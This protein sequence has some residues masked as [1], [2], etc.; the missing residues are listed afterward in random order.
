VPLENRV[1]FLTLQSGQKVEFPFE[2]LIVFATNIRPE[3]LVDEAFLRRIQYKIFAQS[4]TP[5]EFAQIFEN[6]CRKR[7][8]PYDPA[9]VQWLFEHH[10]H[11]RRRPLRAC[12]PRDLISQALSLAEY[13]DEPPVLTRA[14]LDAACETYFVDD[15][16][17]PPVEV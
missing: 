10:Y 8:I 9:L 14:F 6:Y 2:A 17:T 7:A 1:D 3:E 12:H 13:L 16:E 4:P 5:E 11:P 15:A